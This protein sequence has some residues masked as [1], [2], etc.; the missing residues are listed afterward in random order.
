MIL[1]INGG[2]SSI[3]FALFGAGPSPERVAAG[4][5]P[6]LHAATTAATTPARREERPSPDAARLTPDDAARRVAAWAHDAAAG[7]SIAVVVHRLVHGGD[8]FV[9]PCAL[10]ADVLA[11][12][13][14][15]APL[16]PNHLPGE[17]ALVRATAA[18]FPGVPQ[19]ACFDTAFHHDLP[20]A[21]RTIPVPDAARLG[22]RR[23]GFHGISYT[24][25]MA[26]LGR[27]GAAG[28]RIVLAHLGSGA[29]LAAVRDGRCVDTSMGMTPA[30][31]LVM[32]TRAG[33]LDPGVVTFLQRTTGAD[34]E[35]TE[36]L[37]SAEAGLRAI[38]ET[39]ADMAA[40]LAQEAVDARAA[41]AVEVFCYQ[42]TKWIGAYAAA[43]GGL[44]TLV[45]TGGIGERAPA[46]RARASA[47]LGFLGLDIDRAANEAN[48]TVISTPGSRVTARVIPTDEALVMARAARSLLPATDDRGKETG[49]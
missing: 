12:L 16:A 4:T 33:D 28:G 43:L 46:I 41:L 6:G 18:A 42:L 26:E 29:S 23:F 31:G 36:R 19:V 34:A 30:G 11:D 35:T 37:L 2:S 17:L 20:A 22:I 3:K 14:R 1:T 39:T 15:L 48:R 47:P 49:T 45:F 5:L 13:D 8:T 40:L 24:F 32:S 38:S 7:A 10:T 21:A 27:L 25:L 44:D 9:K